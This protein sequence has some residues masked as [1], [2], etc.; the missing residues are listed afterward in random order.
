MQNAPKP[1]TYLS[2]IKQV[3]CNRWYNTPNQ[4][5]G[6]VSFG[7]EV[8]WPIPYRAYQN[9]DQ[10]FNL[11]FELSTNSTKCACFCAWGGE[12]NPAGRLLL[13]LHAHGRGV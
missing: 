1:Q 9:P 7:R 3:Y 4:K 8:A 10:F 11:I 2:V 12:T 6:A 13:V 5:W